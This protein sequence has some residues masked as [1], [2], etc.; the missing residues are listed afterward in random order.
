MKVTDLQSAILYGC[1]D[2]TQAYHSGIK[3][4]LCVLQTATYGLAKSLGLQSDFHSFTITDILFPNIGQ[5]VPNKVLEEYGILNP[6]QQLNVLLILLNDRK[7]WTREAIVVFL[8]QLIE[9]G[10]I[11]PILVVEN[12]KQILEANDYENRNS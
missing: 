6:N 3:N 2:T 8:D 4:C 9:N 10:D 1:E 12:A 5:V 7:H 11:E